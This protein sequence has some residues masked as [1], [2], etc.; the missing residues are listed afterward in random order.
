M[1]FRQIDG[2]DR[3][4]AQ[5][6][7]RGQRATILRFLELAAGTD[8]YG[9]KAFDSGQQ[10]GGEAARDWFACGYTGNL[11]DAAITVMI[12]PRPVVATTLFRPE[13][14]ACAPFI[15]NSGWSRRNR[16]SLGRR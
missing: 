4:T 12:A 13:C 9:A 8:P 2:R 3:A 16:Q 14:S 6:L 7:D 11:F 1:R 15:S 10:G 5:R